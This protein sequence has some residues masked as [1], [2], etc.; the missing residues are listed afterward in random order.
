MAPVI[1]SLS[2]APQGTNQGSYGQTLT[3]NGTGLTGTTSAKIGS[4]TVSATVNGA[5][6]VVT[7]TVPSGCGVASVT[8][9][10]AGVTSNALSFYYIDSPFVS[11]L[12]PADG[13]AATPP[14]V[15]IAGEILL[16]T[17]RVQVGGVTATLTTPTS[18]AQ[19][20]ATPA[21]VTPVGASPWTQTQ[22]VAVRTAGGTATLANS[23]TFYDTP[24]I[25][26]LSPDNGA[27]DTEVIITGTAFVGS[28]ISVTFDGVDADFSVNSDTQILAIAPAGPTGAI[29]VVVTTRGGSSAAATFTYP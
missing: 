3:I 9:T 26:T 6:T 28:A 5:G 29:D 22:S 16:T 27:A 21:S 12:N 25:T 11:S 20:S 13:S 17:N 1:T 23:F 18:D 7:C 24:T 19:V 15:T 4:R 2:A 8:V 10:T 14:S